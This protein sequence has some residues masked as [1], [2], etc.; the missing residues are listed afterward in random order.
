MFGPLDYA[1]SNHHSVIYIETTKSGGRYQDLGSLAPLSY[2]LVALLV[3]MI[4][5]TGAHGMRSSIP[6]ARFDRS[7]WYNFITNPYNLWVASQG[8]FAITMLGATLVKEPLEAVILFSIVGFSWAISS[9]VPYSVLSNE[10][11]SLDPTE[12]GEPF[13]GEETRLGTWPP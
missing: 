7:S 6:I 2:S 13:F 3:A 8:V 9:R 11:R 10:L 5:P 1:A 12:D 4:L